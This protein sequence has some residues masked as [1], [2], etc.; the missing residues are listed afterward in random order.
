[1]LRA[2]TSHSCIS[3]PITQKGSWLAIESSKIQKTDWKQWRFGGWQDGRARFQSWNWSD[4]APVQC[5]A[6]LGIMGNAHLVGWTITGRDPMLSLQLW[7]VH[8]LGFYTPSCFHIMLFQVQSKGSYLLNRNH[9]FLN[10]P[11][12]GLE[13]SEVGLYACL[14]CVCVCEGSMQS[15]GHLCGADGST[16]SG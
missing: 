16:S 13:S 4:L 12:S 5:Y 3:H 6:R 9:P 7:P 11:M 8:V 1:M 10:A 15:S 2:I 14:M